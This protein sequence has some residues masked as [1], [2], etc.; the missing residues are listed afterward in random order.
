MFESCSNIKA[1]FQKFASSYDKLRHKLPKLTDWLA[2]ESKTINTERDIKEF[3]EVKNNKFGTYYDKVLKD[4]ESKVVLGLKLLKSMSVQEIERVF[5]NIKVFHSYVTTLL[6]PCEMQRVIDQMQ[7]NSSPSS[8]PDHFKDIKDMAGN[9]WDIQEQVMTYLDNSLFVIFLGHLSSATLKQHGFTKDYQRRKPGIKG[10]H[11]RNVQ[12]RFQMNEFFKDFC[13]REYKTYEDDLTIAQA[14]TRCE[15]EMEEEKISF[16]K[17]VSLARMKEYLKIDEM[18]KLLDILNNGPSKKNKKTTSRDEMM[19]NL[20]NLDNLE[21]ND[22]P[23]IN[24]EDT[25]SSSPGEDK[26]GKLHNDQTGSAASTNYTAVDAFGARRHQ[27]HN[28][29]KKIHSKK[30]TSVVRSQN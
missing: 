1:S 29:K 9:D 18:K 25:K 17:T 30:R 23:L 4:S 15:K 21:S 16:D 6:L 8:T 24:T 5:A 7:L 27:I 10:K 19:D 2:R 11:Y 14:K 26:F 22:A 13:D 28:K 12:C 3:L 20:E